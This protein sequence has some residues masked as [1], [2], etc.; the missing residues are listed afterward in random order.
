MEDGSVVT[1]QRDERSSQS[2]SPRYEDDTYAWAIEQAALL[3]S[4]RFDDLDLINLADEVA[5]VANRD[6]EALESD[7][8]RVLQHILKWDHQSER[9]GRSWARTIKEHRRRVVRRLNRSP[10]L[11]SRQGE[12]LAEA[13]ERGRAEALQETDLPDAVFPMVNPYTWDEVMAREIDWPD[14]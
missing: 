2:T 14:L 4:R 3:R 1:A 10:S 9:R 7:L 13:Y 12:A 8:S 6:Y 11:K 5:D